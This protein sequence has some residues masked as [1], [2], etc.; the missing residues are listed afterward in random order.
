MIAGSGKDYL[1]LANS[2]QLRDKLKDMSVPDLIQAFPYEYDS[3]NQ[4]PNSYA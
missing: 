2:C 3:R 4:Q 1:E